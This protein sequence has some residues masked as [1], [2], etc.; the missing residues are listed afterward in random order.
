MTLA[1]IVAVAEN[2]VI[3]N[4]GDLPWRLSADL[5]RF[6]QLTMGHHV[7]MGRKTFESIR[8]P[9][10]GRTLI[11]ITRQPNY[12]A[13]GALIA[14]SLD[15]ALRLA[16]NDDEPFVIGGAEI[17][18]LALPKADQMYQTIVHDRPAGDTFFPAWKEAE[19]RIVK[20]EHG[21]ADEKNSA[22][23]TF[24]TLERFTSEARP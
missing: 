15:E 13:G 18:R 19:W 7:I 8:R 4:R 6:R 16:E 22:D 3:G 21:Q 5:R 12:Q 17:F 24:R 2:G 23:Y 9:L 1:L 10:P 11:V 20:E 14:T